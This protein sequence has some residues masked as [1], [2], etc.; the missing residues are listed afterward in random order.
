MVIDFTKAKSGS[1]TTD[2]VKQVTL[3]DVARESNV[4][5]ST[6]SLVL[7]EKPGFPAETRQRVMDVAKA[8]GYRS[9][10]EVSRPITDAQSTARLRN[11]GLLV[12][13]IA[14]QPPLV[15]P[16]YSYVLAG[17]EEACRRKQS[18]LIYSAL[19]VDEQN[20]VVETP[21]LLL[22]GL[23][24]GLLL[25]GAFVDPKLNAFLKHLGL[26]VVLVDAYSSRDQYDS[27]L[28]DNVRGVAAAVQHLIDKGHTHIGLI[29]T[30]ANAYPSIRE[31]RVG[32]EQALEN[33]GIQERYFADCPPY[34]ASAASAIV[35][36]LA[37]HPQITAIMACNDEVAIASMRRAQDLGLNVPSDLSV[38]GFDD[39][40]VAAAVSPALTTMRVDKVAM[41]R[42]A[43]QLLGARIEF[44]DSE[45]ITSVLSPRLI[46]RQSVAAIRR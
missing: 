12:K 1:G 26:P 42:M 4:S 21:R 35:D 37:K 19:P 7:R 32:Y 30:S 17:I 15:N 27:V 36:L 40:D 20:I 44:P 11:V 3:A 9:R 31:R 14:G 45:R 6:A 33:N 10:N 38:I 25:V 24:D 22:E 29:G 13:S 39:I 28:S 23:A 2:L 34:A 43:V 5:L 16:F 18:N 41:G 8:L 46:E